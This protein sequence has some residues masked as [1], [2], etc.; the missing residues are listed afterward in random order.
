ML[1]K[2]LIISVGEQE[3]IGNNQNPSRL[4]NMKIFQRVLCFF[5]ADIKMRL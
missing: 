1:Q 3:N 4:L 5:C 2:Y